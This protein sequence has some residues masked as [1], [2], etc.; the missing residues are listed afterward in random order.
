MT[1]PDRKYGHIGD[2]AADYF[3]RAAAAQA[4]VDPAKLAAAAELLEAAYERGAFVYVCG[5]GGS[6]S[7]SNHLTC[8]HL[9]GVQTDTDLLPRVV[10][11]AATMETIT[12]IANDISFD[13]IFVYQLRTLAR[14]GDVLISISSSGNSENVV[15]AC[16]WAR[17]NG[18]SVISMTGFSGGRSAKLAH[19]N[20]HVDGDNYGVLEDTH[21]GLMHILAQFIRQTRMDEDLVAERKF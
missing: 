4:S 9:K 21:Q 10:S 8:D 11:L 5:N 7:I 18:V 20:L 16:E 3:G 1:F 6:A 14:E 2:F 15:R 12:A 19:V 13:D 17:D